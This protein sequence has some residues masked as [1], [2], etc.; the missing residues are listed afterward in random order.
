M[1]AVRSYSV[2]ILLYFFCFLAAQGLQV[3]SVEPGGDVTLPCSAGDDSIRAVEWTRTDL[4]PEYVLYYRDGRSDP[5][6]Q[7]PSFKGRV[8]LTDRE[9]K[10]GN[11]SLVIKNVI[12]SD[13]GTYECRVAKGGPSRRKRANIKTDPIRTIQLEVTASGSEHRNAGNGNHINTHVGLAV[14]L[15]AF[16]LLC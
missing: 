13:R 15:I 4:E 8:D 10:D 7:H 5:T 14:G 6:Y 16:L 12:I 3:I 11:V 2:Y 1:A 9:M